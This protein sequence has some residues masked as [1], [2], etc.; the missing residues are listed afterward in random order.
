MNYAVEV[1]TSSTTT[2][3]L[4]TTLAAEISTTPAS[5]VEAVI[6]AVS[7]ATTV[8]V[9]EVV[10][11]LVNTTMINAT[12]AAERLTESSPSTTEGTPLPVLVS[13]VFGYLMNASVTSTIDDLSK[14]FPEYDDFHKSVDGIRYDT[15]SVLQ[16]LKCF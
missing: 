14:D 9:T 11:S 10:Q 5:L 2:T 8:G 1:V 3:A 6:D 7:N 16:I 12:Q 13:R 15:V 4:S